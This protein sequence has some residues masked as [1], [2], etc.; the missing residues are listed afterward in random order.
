[1]KPEPASHISCYINFAEHLQ[2][3]W[4]VNILYPG[5]PNEWSTEDW[6]RFLT[7]I[8]SFGYTC[9]EYWIVPTLFDRPALQGGGIYESFASTMRQV[10][11]IA[12]EVGL[13]TKYLIAVNCI[14]PDWYYACPNDPKDLQLIRDLWRHWAR[15]LPKTDIVGIFPGDPGGCN[16]NGCTHEDFISLAL[17]L[18]EVVRL[19]NPTAQFELGTWGTPFSGWGDD[20]RHV[21]NWDGTWKMLCDPDNQT[22]ETPCH[23]WN[24]NRERAQIAMEYF[25]KRLPEF[26]KDM[27]VAINLGFSI[28]GDDTLGGDATNWARAIS[29]THPITTW[30]YSLAEGELISYPHWRLPRMAARRQEERAA[31]HYTG[32]MSYTMSP[33][34][35]LLSLYA[36][37]KFLQDPTATADGVSQEF[38]SLVFGNTRLGLLFEAFE[39]VEGWGHYPRR[40]WTNEELAI[41]FDEMIS[42]LEAADMSRCAL[43]IFPDPETY[44]KDVLWFARKFREM[45][46]PNPDR[47]KIRADYWKEALSIYDHAPKAVDERSEAAA[48][49]F[50][51]IRS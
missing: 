24:G 42:L 15:E 10:T 6:R 4:N 14:G 25:M 30:D 40:T 18:V 46:S 50:A 26:P 48:D 45:V 19:E 2:N 32:G 28:D 36:G 23:I 16:R 39:V 38:C 41:A 29:N 17:G 51:Q 22:P 9:F 31:A 13:K 47:K 49:R 11:E 21:P 1:M 43:P 3:R 8:R 12:H 34:I 27:M 5:A 35:S 44:R 37:A 20:L 7:M 33:K